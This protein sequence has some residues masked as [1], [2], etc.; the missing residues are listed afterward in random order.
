MKYIVSILLLFFSFSLQGQTATF[1]KIVAVQNDKIVKRQFNESQQW[2]RRIKYI[3]IAKDTI[4]LS[5][6]SDSITE[7]NIIPIALHRRLENYNFE[8][9]DCININVD[10]SQ[11]LTLFEVEWRRSKLKDIHYRSY[12]V[13]IE[14]KSDSL[15]KIGFG[16]NVRIILEALDAD[17]TWKPI[18]IPYMYRCGTGL[19]D[20]Y[21][22]G[23]QIACV[24]IPIYYGDFRTQLRLKLNNHFSKPFSASINKKQFTK[25]K[26]AY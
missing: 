14:N 5:E 4:Q 21:L 19:T 16:Q 25:P 22:Q 9:N 13:V 10:T 6:D 18:E 7:N 11:I 17:N 3:G 15:Y 12:P 26:G 2:Y 20:L 23:H 8:C 1:P 24:L